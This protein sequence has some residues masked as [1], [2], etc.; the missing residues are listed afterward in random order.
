MA[1][2]K[3]R[4]DCYLAVLK[5]F[6]E[7]YP[8]AHF[9]VITSTAHSVLAPSKHLLIE[10][11]IFKKSDGSK[12]PKMPFEMY[13]ELFIEEI[14]RSPSALERLER[15]EEINKDKDIFLVCYEKDPSKCHRSIIARLIMREV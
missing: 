13:K 1:E 10:A 3:I 11:G 6:K 8:N 7:K 2:N 5:R 4:I 14:E 12:N 9:E 15:L